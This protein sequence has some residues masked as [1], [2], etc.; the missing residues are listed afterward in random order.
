MCRACTRRRCR[1]YRPRTLS[2]RYPT[3]WTSSGV[4]SILGLRGAG[5]LRL[6]LQLCRSGPV[7]GAAASRRV[8]G[9][10]LGRSQVSLNEAKDRGQGRGP[11]R[12]LASEPGEYPIAQGRG[13]RTQDLETHWF[14]RLESPGI[15]HPRG[16]PAIP[17]G[18]AELLG[19]Q[20]QGDPDKPPPE[21]CRRWPWPP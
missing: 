6:R 9:R 12:S 13:P 20:G 17:V 4:P 16:A 18:I 3:A 2:H 1:R 11:C 14:G 8:T 5:V 7:V 19:P 15:A 21:L 10:P